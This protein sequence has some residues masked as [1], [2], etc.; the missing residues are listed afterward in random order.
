MEAKRAQR[1]LEGT[2][3]G[4]LSLLWRSESVYLERGCLQLGLRRTGR[5]WVGW[6]LKESVVGTADISGRLE[7]EWKLRKCGPQIETIIF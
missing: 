4:H 5:R 6:C 1:L 3:T 7:S 2:K